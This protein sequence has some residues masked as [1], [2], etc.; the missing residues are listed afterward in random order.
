MKESIERI[1][2]TYRNKK[3]KEYQE[4]DEYLAEYKKRYMPDRINQNFQVADIQFAFNNRKLIQL[5]R[6]RGEAMSKGNIQDTIMSNIKINKYIKSEKGMEEM[7][8]IISAF[9]T[10]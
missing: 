8:T 4:I 10:F 1:K 9:V 3:K 6:K 7:N 2:R 5:M